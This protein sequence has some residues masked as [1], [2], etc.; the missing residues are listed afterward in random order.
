MGDRPRA[1]PRSGKIWYSSRER[2]CG[3]GRTSNAPLSTTNV[4]RR[5]AENVDAANPAT[6][7]TDE[8]GGA[9]AV[10]KNLTRS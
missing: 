4:E 10:N 8:G 1:R 5:T 2:W 7:E 3:T 9:V 6:P